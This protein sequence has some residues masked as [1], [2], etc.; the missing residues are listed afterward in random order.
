MDFNEYLQVNESLLNQVKTEFGKDYYDEF[1]AELRKVFIAAYQIEQTA[2]DYYS[3]ENDFS[4]PEWLRV[5]VLFLSKY[6]GVFLFIPA[7][8][9]AVIGGVGAL[10]IE[11]LNFFEIV[12][13]VLKWAVLPT[14]VIGVLPFSIFMLTGYLRTARS[15]FRK[16]DRFTAVVPGDTVE[17]KESYVGIFTKVFGHNF[18]EQEKIDRSKDLFKH[19]HVIVAD[20]MLQS[21]K[22]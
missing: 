12:I 10:L 18:S 2:N 1:V 5:P 4:V 21:K 16:L 8:I 13:P 3:S 15:H 14:F 19:M 9:I 6:V 22:R 20:R 11:G 7:I 17:E